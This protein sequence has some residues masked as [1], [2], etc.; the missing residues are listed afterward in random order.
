M[1]MSVKHITYNI[2]QIVYFLKFIYRLDE[3]E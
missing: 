2:R 1:D 3:R